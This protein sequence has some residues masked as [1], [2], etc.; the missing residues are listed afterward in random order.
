[1]K[2][3][4]LITLSCAIFLINSGCS[5]IRRP[6]IDVYEQGIE[7]WKA[8]KYEMAIKTLTP[9]ITKDSLYVP[10]YTV[11][12]H[13]H[14]ELGNYEE[15]SQILE[16]I[17]KYDD[18]E[19]ASNFYH[20]MHARLHKISNQEE[21]VSFGQFLL[22]VSAQYALDYPLLLAIIRERSEFRILPLP[23]PPTNDFRKGNGVGLLGLTDKQ[24]ELL[25]LRYVKATDYPIGSEDERLDPAKSIYY[26]ARHISSLL[27]ENMFDP[28][29]SDLIS[30]L[31]QFISGDTTLIDSE[32]ILPEIE[33]IVSGYQYYRH[34]Q[35]RI[36]AA[37]QKFYENN[38]FPGN[39]FV[40]N[41][42]STANGH[43]NTDLSLYLHQSI[44]M[45]HVWKNHFHRAFYY[46]NIALI[47]ELTGDY[48]ITEEYY[49]KALLILPENE[50]IVFNYGLFLF[51][52]GELEEALRQLN[53]IKPFSIKRQ[54]ANAVKGYIYLLLN[55]GEKLSEL[56]SDRINLDKEDYYNLS[57]LYQYK[58]DNADQAAMSFRK[59]YEEN[60]NP[61]YAA[62]YL[63]VIYANYFKDQSLTKLTPYN[64]TARKYD[65]GYIWPVDLRY[66]SSDY[67]WRPHPFQR[68]WRERLMNLDFHN[69]L[70]IPGQS[71][72]PVRAAA[73]GK[74]TISE[75]FVRAGEAVFITH[76]NGYITTYMHL[77]E[78]FVETGELVEQGQLIGTLGNTGYSTG[79]HL[80]FGMF[81][82]SGKPA[83]PL[84]YL[85]VY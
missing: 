37:I 5:S 41:N 17:R 7:F 6:E 10:L 60:H 8:E 83:N 40:S 52:R 75:A 18:N 77:D 62:N 53:L 14:Y 84:L 22:D 44:G 71:G 66:I 27:Q 15:T 68:S 59:A 58:S 67:G 55:E 31:T 21:R 13:S 78:R 46:N 1:M 85:P 42:I 54:E 23:Y 47:S 45:D 26:T 3:F 79:P 51:E 43:D 20:S 69:G 81:N 32:Y 36:D 34:N 49:H 38:H 63:A 19:L 70:D 9:F 35:E 48:K 12:A 33:G 16:K 2:S 39:P 50:V 82:S 24:A 57:G 74:V 73:S 25:G 56:L 4:F 29:N 64:K 65:T 28:K 30:A 72:L 61:I 76:P 80:H 11:L